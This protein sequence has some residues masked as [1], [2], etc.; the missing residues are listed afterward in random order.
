MWSGWKAKVSGVWSLRCGIL[1][2]GGGEIGVEA[3]SEIV[4][5]VG[6]VECRR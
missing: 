4:G 5:R 2:G 3:G 1:V 6:L